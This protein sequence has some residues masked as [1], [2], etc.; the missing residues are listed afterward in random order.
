M[1]YAIT[2]CCKNRSP[3]LQNRI[4]GIVMAQIVVDCIR[5][6]E[7]RSTWSPYGFV[8]MPDHFHL[9][10]K[11]LQGNLS[12]A[13]KSLSNF[14]ARRI[15]A[16]LRREGPFWQ[17]GYYEH[18]IRGERSLEAYLEYIAMNPVRAGLVQDFR[19]WPYSSFGNPLHTSSVDEGAEIRRQEAAPTATRGARS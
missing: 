17:T 11:L 15:N 10:V 7:S 16:A 18:L 5:E 3:V 13:M 1:V 4:D 2:K 12:R 6:I 14:T 19:Q 9:V 8:I